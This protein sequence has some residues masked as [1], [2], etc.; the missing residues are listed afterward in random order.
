MHFTM[1]TEMVSNRVF[2]TE[3]EDKLLMLCLG[4]Q[5]QLHYVRAHKHTQDDNAS[6][7]KGFCIRVSK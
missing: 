3:T 5:K 4:H 2:H 6:P 1:T 7:F